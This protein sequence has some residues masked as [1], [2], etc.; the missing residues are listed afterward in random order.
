MSTYIKV[1]PLSISFLIGFLLLPCCL[2]IVS[3][4]GSAQEDAST[5]QIPTDAETSTVSDSLGPAL[6]HVS[7]CIQQFPVDIGHSGIA[8]KFNANNFMFRTS[9]RIYFSNAF[10]RIRNDSLIQAVK[11]AGPPGWFWQ[12]RILS[13][14]F[15]GGDT[16]VQRRIRNTARMWERVCAVRFDFSTNA[17]PDI[18]ISFDKRSGTWSHIGTESLH[19]D[20]NAASMNYD[21][22]SPYSYQHVYDYYVLHEFGH[23]LGLVHEHQSPKAGIQWDS[24]AVY[25]CFLPPN[26]KWDST[27]VQ[28]NIFFRYDFS[29]VN[30]TEY[31]PS[32]I[33]VYAIDSTWTKDHYHVDA[34]TRIS[35]NDAHFVS[36]LFPPI[37]SVGVPGLVCNE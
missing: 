6:G 15:L 11:A 28:N 29:E 18:V 10:A 5:S 16:I 35:P 31:D 1:A 25:T 8:F 26:G 22:L 14:N 7:P 17:N 30:C 13:V 20:P 19:R 4:G 12:K 21:D 32:S 3:C 27:M 33:M 9:S 36:R 24:T 37:G 23:A 34:T 2:A